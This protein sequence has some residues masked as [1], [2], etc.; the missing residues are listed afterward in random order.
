MRDV[1][2]TTAEVPPSEP[3]VVDLEELRAP[4]ETLVR[5]QGMELIEFGVFYSKARKGFPPSVKVNAV[6]YKPGALGTGDCAKAHHSMLPWLEQAFPGR[7]ISM[8]VS[9]PGINRVIKD[10]AELALY[11]GRGLRVWRTD[12][13]D[14]SAGILEDA[15]GQWITIKGKEGLI[16][17]DYGIIAKAKLD[18][19]QEE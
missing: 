14:W 11:R 13:S 12:I 6:V 5:A 4:L 17:L 10:K 9:T 8:E 19:S 18:P 3:G 7:D 1:A 15:D 2:K 16:Q